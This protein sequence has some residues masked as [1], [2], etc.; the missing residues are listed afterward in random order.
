MLQ[1]L[2]DLIEDP[3]GLHSVCRAVTADQPDSRLLPDADVALVAGI[4]PVDIAWVG[5]LPVG[6]PVLYLARTVA[7]AK[8]ALKRHPEIQGLLTWDA[9]GDEI[10]AA[11]DAVVAGLFVGSLELVGVEEAPIENPEAGLTPRETEVLGMLAEGYLNKEIA[12][13]LGISE[14]T[15]K[16]HLA[17]IYE[18]LGAA[19][20]VEAL[21]RGMVL[22]LL[23]L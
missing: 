2:R 21:R 8:Q 12:S 5:R 14:N 16:Y 7:E 1:G 11:I 19:N 18:K 22:G 13:N 10:L 4:S 23:S 17:S 9:S 20:R 6:L 15:V 3:G